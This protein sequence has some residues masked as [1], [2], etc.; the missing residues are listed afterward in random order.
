MSQICAS[1]EAKDRN[2]FKCRSVCRSVVYCSKTCQTA[3]WDTHKKNC[4]PYM[5]PDVKKTAT[6]FC[7][8]LECKGKTEVKNTKSVKELVGKKC[9]IRCFLNDQMTQALWDTGSQVCAID[10]GWKENHLPD[11]DLR[12]VLELLDPLQSLHLEAANGTDMPFIGWVEVSFKL[13]ADDS[14]LLIP[15]LVLRGRQQQHPIIGFNVIEHFVQHSQA[16]DALSNEKEKLVKSVRFAF[17]HLRNKKAQAFIDAV[18]VGQTCEYS[19]RTVK[20]RIT[21]PKCSSVEVECRVRIPPVREEHILVFEPH[22]NPQWPEGLEFC[23]TVVLLKAGSTPKIV[24]SVQNPTGHD[25]ILPGKTSVGVVQ[26]VQSVYPVDIFNQQHTPAV[27]VHHIQTEISE[28]ATPSQEQWDPPVNLT[29][30]NDQQRQVVCQMLREESE[31]FSKTDDDIGCIPSLQ[32]KISLKDAEPVSK[33]YLSVPKP[34]Y[35]EM[36]DYL[37]DLIAQG[38][39]EKSSSPYSSPVV[40]VRKKD[41]TL[42]LCIDY[43]ELNRKTHPDRHPI[44]RVQD[45]MDNLGG[46]RLFSLLD[47]GK[48][49]HQGFV[50]RDSRHLT[51][52]V[53][54]WGLYEWVRIPFGLMNAPAAFQR[55]MEECL[56]GLRDEIC[57][58]YLDD[59]LVFS[60]TFED[61]VDHVRQVLQRLRE[62]GIKLKPKKCDLFKAEVRYLGRIVSAEGNKMDPADTAAVRA[63]KHKK[64]HNVAD[65]P[66]LSHPKR[67]NVQKR[68]DNKA[69]SEDDSE[70]EENYYPAPLEPGET[71]CDQSELTPEVCDPTPENSEHIHQ[72]G[73]TLPVLEEE[74][75]RAGGTQHCSDTE[76]SIS[77]PPALID[78]G[79]ERHQR[80]QRS[81]RRPKVFTYDTLGTPACH[82]IGTHSCSWMSWNMPQLNT[83]PTYYQL[84]PYGY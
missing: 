70:D 48:A 57:V 46:N 1:C 75:E 18:K 29:H 74:P 17:P 65:F 84:T 24:I 40:C 31:S 41:G 9:L 30:L 28:K 38:W 19:V 67:R 78:C 26:S 34:L 43:R 23:D 7:E 50:E 66:V 56:E 72:T 63:L 12:D 44:P 45:M 10:E 52:F 62:H 36:K 76:D 49:Y 42:R 58:P 8:K 73:N 25:I 83:V 71:Y 81:H 20:E 27:T 64:P 80:P 68:E 47:Q 77:S 54:P 3:H 55:C 22:D 33:M 4:K 11:L 60:R 6:R 16:E 61:H 51:A 14:E 21:V 35:K 53:T 32:M 37:E 39:V 69:S 79:E 5:C 59:I 82:K 15:I 13:T 2:L